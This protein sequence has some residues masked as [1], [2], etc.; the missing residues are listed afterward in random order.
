MARRALRPRRLSRASEAHP[1]A[2]RGRLDGGEPSDDR[3]DDE[4][5]EYEK[6]DARRAFETPRRRVSSNPPGARVSS[7]RVRIGDPDARL[8]LRFCCDTFQISRR[9]AR[10]CPSRRTATL[11]AEG[12]RA[13]DMLLILSGTTRSDAVP[14][15]EGNGARGPPERSP[16]LIG[17]SAFLTRSARRETLRVAPERDPEG[18]LRERAWCIPWARLSSTV[19]A[20][21]RRRRTSRRCWRRRVRCRIFCVGS[22]PSV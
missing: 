5:E 2:T 12:D 21:A 7:S 15:P 18:D 19:F 11:Y 6:E 10:A 17:A 22:Y 16:T 4:K 3:D 9:A 14:W 8:P 20:S 13:D 1:R